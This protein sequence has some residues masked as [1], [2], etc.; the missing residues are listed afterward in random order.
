MSREPED[1]QLGVFSS[2]FCTTAGKF[3][4][5]NGMYIRKKPYR[6]GRPSLMEKGSS[7][8]MPY[9]QKIQPLQ[10]HPIRSVPLWKI[11]SGW[12]HRNG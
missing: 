1:Q 9:P 5:I 12:F 4:A 8:R 10:N 11:R 3:S 7:L 2:E 6:Q